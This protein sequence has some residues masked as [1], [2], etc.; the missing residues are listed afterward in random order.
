MNVHIGE[1]G[2]SQRKSSDGKF[3]TVDNQL[4]VLYH[5]REQ[6]CGC[7]ACF[8]IC[9]VQAIIMLPDEEGFLYPVVDAEKCVRCYKC[10][11]VC[12][13]KRE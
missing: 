13:F 2:I 5:K 10:T 11:R 4:P 6:C 3:V 1:N 9:P 7:T 8:A 12:A